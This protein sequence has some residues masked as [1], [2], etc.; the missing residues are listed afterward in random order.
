[1]NDVASM[2]LT[3]PGKGP[4]A[5]THGVRDERR[6]AGMIKGL[7]MGWFSNLKLD[8]RRRNRV[9]VATRAVHDFSRRHF[10][11][12]RP[13]WSLIAEDGWEECV[14]YQTYRADGPP[15]APLPHRFLLVKLHDL[16]VTPLADSYRPEK[17][18]L[19]P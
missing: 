4:V 13:D 8:W 2:D 14:V 16:S 18:S 6:Q 1:M 7:V 5:E 10:P 12:Q 3:G 15:M 9:K 11:G 19:F 17:W